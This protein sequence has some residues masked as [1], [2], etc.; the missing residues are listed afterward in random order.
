MNNIVKVSGAMMVQSWWKQ[1]IKPDV[2]EQ[3]NVNGEKAKEQSK[4]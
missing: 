4:N 1:T 2:P 3:E